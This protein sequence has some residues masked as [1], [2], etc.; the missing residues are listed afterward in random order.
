MSEKI[1][2][3][4]SYKTN[5][6]KL[7]IVWLFGAGILSNAIYIFGLGYYQG[8]LK[9]MGFIYDLFPLT[10]NEAFMW[11][12]SASRRFAADIIENFKP[13]YIIFSNIGI[14]SI[15][16]VIL[17]FL[18]FEENKYI[19]KNHF[20]YEKFNILNI[21]V[22][23]LFKKYI[24]LSIFLSFKKKIERA[25]CYLRDSF[26]YSI[27]KFPFMIVYFFFSFFW[28]ILKFLFVNEKS[29]KAAIISYI[30]LV[31]FIFIPIVSIFWWFFP[32]AGVLYGE[33]TADKVI[34]VFHE[35]K[36][37]CQ[38]KDSKWEKC[39]IIKD[40]KEL[41]K[42]LLIARVENRLAVMTKNGPLTISE[43]SKYKFY[44]KQIM[45]DSNSTKVKK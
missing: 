6:F 35:R 36:D 8:Y 30:L 24:R 40:E 19:L 16:W 11:A 44:T 4:Q 1:E 34:E 21:K 42:G 26:I 33:K 37:L 13:E 32:Y 29:L 45:V 5:Y 25:K 10:G 28:F 38:P 43:P 22:G 12:Y 31:I 41:I 15:I 2:K 23:Q 3:N 20:F 17:T 7:I 27:L 14:F 39:I 18:N 9:G